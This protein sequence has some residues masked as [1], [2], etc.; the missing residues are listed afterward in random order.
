MGGTHSTLTV[1]DTLNIITNSILTVKQDCVTF[2]TTDNS[3]IQYGKHNTATNIIQSI[4]LKVSEYCLSDIKTDNNFSNDVATKI[5][6]ALTNVGVA[7]AQWMDDDKN[8]MT[9]T[10]AQDIK[11]SI[12][13][14][15]IQDCMVTLSGKNLVQQ[16][17]VE[18]VIVGAIQTDTLDVMKSCVQKLDEMNTL[19]NV[20]TTTV[21]QSD[22]NTEKNMFDPF[23]KMFDHMMDALNTLLKLPLE[24]VMVVVVGL[25]AFI[26]LIVFIIMIGHAL[27]GHKQKQQ[28]T[29]PTP[30]IIH[31][32]IPM[33]T[34]P[35]MHP[36]PMP[37]PHPIHHTP[38]APVH[39]TDYSNLM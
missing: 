26:I 8:T 12:V 34:H 7:G 6:N 5:T 37:Q 30:I 23:A 28:K 29:T 22:S 18:N 17:G 36:M 4:K 33:S 10:I 21:N 27:G 25:F 35:M 32:Q 19:T 2:V 14:T 1:N 3:I 13:T 39:Q 38:L 11:T 24:L 16:S 9:T 31:N 15:D 20:I